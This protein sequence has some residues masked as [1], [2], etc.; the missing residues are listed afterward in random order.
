MHVSFDFWFYTCFLFLSA[1]DWLK[2]NVV[3]EA[4]EARA[5]RMSVA[6]AQNLSQFSNPEEGKLFD[7]LFESQALLT[8]L[9]SLFILTDML[10]ETIGVLIF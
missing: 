7:I 6:V 5:A 1:E 10:L 8:C 2:P 9:C 3:I 4:F